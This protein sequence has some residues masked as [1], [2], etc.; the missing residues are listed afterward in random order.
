MK[1]PISDKL[2]LYGS[3]V[4]LV[5][6]IIVIAF[7]YFEIYNVIIG[8]FT[9]LLT[10]PFLLFVLFITFVSIKRII[11]E[12]TVVTS[13]PFISFILSLITIIILIIATVIT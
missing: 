2:I 3:I 4:S 6:F 1:K 10:I 7:S 13:S 8:V 12:R 9:E 5:Y 11:K